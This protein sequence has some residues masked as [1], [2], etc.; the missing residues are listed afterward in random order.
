MFGPQ[1]IFWRLIWLCF[2]RIQ[3]R[4]YSITNGGTCL[5]LLYKYYLV[6]RVIMMIVEQ[7]VNMYRLYRVYYSSNP[8]RCFLLILFPLAV[9]LMSFWHVQYLCSKLL[10]ILLFFCYHIAF[11]CL[12]FHSSF[13]CNLYFILDFNFLA[14]FK[15]VF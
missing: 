13:Y 4:I 15:S 1:V 8:P 2:C 9:Q 6:R 14:H 7:P 5:R 11:L 12:S 10:L 3:G